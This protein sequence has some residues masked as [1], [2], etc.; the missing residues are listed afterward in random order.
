M[1][2]RALSEHMIQSTLEREHDA[3]FPRTLWILRRRQQERRK[4]RK[5]QRWIRT[6]SKREGDRAQHQREEQGRRGKSKKGQRGHKGANRSARK[7]R[8]K[9]DRGSRDE[10]NERGRAKLLLKRALDR[11]AGLAQS[12]E[13]RSTLLGGNGDVL[14]CKVGYILSLQTFTS[15]WHLVIFS[16]LNFMFSGTFMGKSPPPARTLLHKYI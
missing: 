13:R 8:P 6:K 2:A 10:A 5:D 3:H 16:L 14:G 9:M 4:E 11:Y 12:E 1:F 7:G 15:R